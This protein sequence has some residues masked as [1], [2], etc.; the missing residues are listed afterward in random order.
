LRRHWKP[1]HGIPLDRL[2]RAD[3]SNRPAEMEIRNGPVA[4]GHARSALSGFF[5]WAISKGLCDLNPV[6]GTAKPP[7]RPPRERALS[8]DEIRAVWLACGDDDFGKIIKLA[9]FQRAMGV[10]C[11]LGAEPVRLPDFPGPLDKRIA[12]ARGPRFNRGIFTICDEP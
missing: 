6:I 9:I 2:T 4:A 12:D 1:L 3:V 10:T 5:A 7:A 8:G 11:S